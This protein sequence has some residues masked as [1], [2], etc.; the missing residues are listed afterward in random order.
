MHCDSLGK[1]VAVVETAGGVLSP[2]PSGNLQADVYRVFDFPTIL[3][4]DGK[5][6]G[7][8]NTITSFESL[9]T[10]GYAVDAIV[11]FDYKKYGNRSFLRHHLIKRQLASVWGIEPPP[12]LEERSDDSRPHDLD[13]YYEQIHASRGMKA[14]LNRIKVQERVRARERDI[15]TTNTIKSV[16][17]PFTQ[18]QTR[19]QADVMSIDSAYGDFF[20][21]TKTPAA[22]ELNSSNTPID[23]M[24]LTQ[25]PHHERIPAFDGSAS[26][27]T[28]GFGH[29]DHS[30][31]LTAAHAAGRYGHVMFANAT[32]A[33]AQQLVSKL[34]HV[35]GGK[36]QKVFFSDNGSTGVEVAIK[37]ALKVSS[38]MYGWDSKKTDIGIIGL[39]ESYHG[40]TIGA[41]DCSQP[42]IF[43]SKVD[44]YQGRGIWFDY[45]KV[46]M[47]N[48]KWVIEQPPSLQAD[49]EN[50]EFLNMDDIFDLD[51]RKASSIFTTYVSHILTRLSAEIN[52]GKKLGALIMEPVILGA[53]GMIMP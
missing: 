26:W 25:L 46:K 43:N 36:M 8:G 7:I 19:S 10:R 22:K 23:Q 29:G 4:G 35:L 38:R 11:L 24:P 45:P 17:H 33:P 3:I 18:H 49:V 21:T 14:I 47:T 41:M 12:K 1:G 48:G 50:N 34:L 40:D 20:V 9:W 13:D 28:Q 6:G 53:G 52:A 42:S 2:A 5:L 44:W 27:W 16:W 51:N 32:H 31:A 39:Q 37:M 30:L 15:L